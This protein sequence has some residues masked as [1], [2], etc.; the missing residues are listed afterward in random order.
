MEKEF[1]ARVVD[2]TMPQEAT[3][4]QRSDGMVVGGLLVMPL[5]H[6]PPF[7]DWVQF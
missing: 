7:E 1:E 6:K 2:G 5:Q 4:R 3:M